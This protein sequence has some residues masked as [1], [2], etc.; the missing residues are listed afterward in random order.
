MPLRREKSLARRRRTKRNSLANCAKA[1]IGFTSTLDGV[2]SGGKMSAIQFRRCSSLALRI[3]R[4]QCTWR[5][6][7]ICWSNEIAALSAFCEYR[8]PRRRQKRKAK[9]VHLFPSRAQHT[10]A[11]RSRRSST[12]SRLC[13]F[14]AACG[15][16]A[17]DA[18]YAALIELNSSA[19]ETPR[20]ISSLTLSRRLYLAVRFTSK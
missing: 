10:R 17:S 1:A 19:D 5:R 20:N 4:F 16:R 3:V 12:A 8:F 7:A 14:P 2:S 11:L 13:D 18:S 6:G 15:G 9:D